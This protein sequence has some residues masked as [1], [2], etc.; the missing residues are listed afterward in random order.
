METCFIKLF[1]VLCNKYWVGPLDISHR[2]DQGEDKVDRKEADCGMLDSHDTSLTVHS[3]LSCWLII[4][5]K[6]RQAEMWGPT[7]ECSVGEFCSLVAGE[8]WESGGGNTVHVKLQ[9]VMG[10]C[11]SS[12]ATA[13]FG[14]I[15]LRNM[16]G[17]QRSNII[18][19]RLYFN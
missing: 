2:A 11:S 6:P 10:E 7:M 18:L 3:P 14:F 8:G 9:H 15:V 12:P 16:K 1:V 19:S 5:N 4:L 13:L 17:L